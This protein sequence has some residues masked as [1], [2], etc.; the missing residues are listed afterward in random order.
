MPDH[1]KWKMTHF[2][3]TKRMK[4]CLVQK[5]YISVLLVHLCILPIVHAQTLIFLSIYQQNTILLQL[6]DIGMVSNILHYL[7]RTTDTSLFYLRESKQQLFG[8]AD[9]GYFSD[10]YKVISQIGYC[11]IAMVLLFDGNLLNK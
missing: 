5:Y 8:Y 2:V 1:L 11:L 7:C 9:A 10:P 3:L 4:N 6:E